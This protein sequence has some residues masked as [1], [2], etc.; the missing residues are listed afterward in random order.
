MAKVHFDIG[1]YDKT[2]EILR[3]VAGNYPKSSAEY[4]AIKIATQALLFACEISTFERFERF[5]RD[6]GKKLSSKERAN[7]KKILAEE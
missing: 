5:L 4:Q 1:E 7:L 2:A 6:S 3:G